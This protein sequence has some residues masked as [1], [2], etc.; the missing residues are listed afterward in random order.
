VLVGGAWV[1]R[2]RALVQVDE[3]DRRRAIAAE[4]QTSRASV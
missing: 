1:V 4:L 3:A 2:E